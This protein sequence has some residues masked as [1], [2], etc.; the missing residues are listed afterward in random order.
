MYDYKTERPYTFSEEGQKQFLSIRDRINRLFKS[1]GAVRMEEAINGECGSSWQMLACVD[2]LVELGEIR[3][4]S[5]PDVAAQH[6]VFI[7][8][9]SE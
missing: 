1:A 8:R 9:R 6:R 7:N 5:Q 4:I 2:R 3:E